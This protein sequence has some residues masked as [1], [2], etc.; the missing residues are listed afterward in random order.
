MAD[1]DPHV[2]TATPQQKPALH[3]GWARPL[4]P[5]EGLPVTEVRIPLAD[6]RKA[7][8]PLTGQYPPILSLRQAAE[9]AQIAPGTLKRKVS[10]GA[11]SKS[12][13]RGKPLRFWR[14]LFVQELM[15]A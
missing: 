3:T 6:V 2:P 9:I 8:E 13:K 7:Y 15:D 12:V 14:D 4:G 5:D 10:E 11:F 1:P